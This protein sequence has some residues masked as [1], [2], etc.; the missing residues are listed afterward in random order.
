MSKIH[1]YATPYT[2][3]TPLL[4]CR[5]RQGGGSLI[6]GTLAAGVDGAVTLALTLGRNA[7]T[8]VKGV[9]CGLGPPGR[10][11]APGDAV[12]GDEPI[13]A[14]ASG[15]AGDVEASASAAA[16]ALIILTTASHT[17]LSR[18]PSTPRPRRLASRRASVWY[19]RMAALALLIVRP[20]HGYKILGRW[21]CPLRRQCSR[22][23]I[24]CSDHHGLEACLIPQLLLGRCRDAGEVLPVPERP[25][26]RR[27]H[28]PQHGTADWRCS[29]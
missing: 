4:M 23:R 20:G 9:K 21:R 3:H 17:V 29:M 1:R 14:E 2:R 7:L 10:T 24:S 6:F 27:H 15:K 19:L 8:G 18:S 22:R 26:R 25:V 11:A 12:G 5:R 16:A 13:G 28:A